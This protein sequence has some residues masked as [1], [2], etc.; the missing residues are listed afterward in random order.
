V[1]PRAG[2]TRQRVVDAAVAI[3]DESGADALTLTRVADRTG[4]APPS[5][6]KHVPGLPALRR[7]VRLRVLAEFDEATR[8]ATLGRA[9]EEALRA[10]ATA[11]R[12]YLR[13]HPH[14]YPFL[15]AAP[16]PGDPEE[17]AMEA[18]VVEVVFAV[19]R[20]YG[21]TG[22]AAVHATRCLRAAING[23]TRLEAVGGFGMPED[24]ETSFGYLLDMVTRGVS[25][26]R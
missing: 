4:V 22:S 19:L 5:L 25:A 18:R 10:L 24:I 26:M 7:L 21:L 23:F 9:G 1:A 6:Y 11:Y 2:L 13:A 17:Q 16:D 12:A 15:E 3:V 14:R 20:G 8:A